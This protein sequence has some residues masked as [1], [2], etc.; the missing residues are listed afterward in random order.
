MTY[1]LR[2]FDFWNFFFAF[3]FGF[4]A[5]IVLLL[6]LLTVKKTSKKATLRWADFSMEQ[7]GVVA[8][9]FAPEFLTQ[10]FE[11]FVAYL[12]LHSACHSDL[13]II[14]KISSSCRS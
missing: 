12:R 6:G 5:V 8:G 13:G 11:H 9:N 4:S 3:P 2:L 14:G 10:L 7:A 1:V